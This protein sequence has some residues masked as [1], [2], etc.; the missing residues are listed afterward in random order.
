[1]MGVMVFG[2]HA[3]V[4]ELLSLLGCTTAPEDRASKKRKEDQKRG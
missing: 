2:I 1:M 3:A 4:A